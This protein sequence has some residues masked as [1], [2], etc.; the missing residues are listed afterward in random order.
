MKIGNENA[1]LNT[2]NLLTKSGSVVV[3]VTTTDSRGRNKTVTNT[4]TV[5]QYAGP[6]IANLTYA[7]GS[8]TGGVWTENNT[9]AD[10]KVMFDL[11]ISLSN[12]TASISLKIDDENRQTLSAQSSGSKVAPCPSGIGNTVL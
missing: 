4:I 8:Y 2:G 11:T 9:G 12:N 6:S 3:T 1:N 10:I 5:Q 7:R